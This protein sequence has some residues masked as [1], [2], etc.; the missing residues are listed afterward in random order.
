MRRLWQII[1]L[2]YKKYDKIAHFVIGMICGLLE[3]DRN[4]FIGLIT[5]KEV[6]DCYKKQSTGFSV[7]DWLSGWGGYEFGS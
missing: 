3:I 7:E 4:L 5:A 1:Q 6:G 2:W